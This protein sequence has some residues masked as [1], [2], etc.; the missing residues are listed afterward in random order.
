M[1]RSIFAGFQLAKKYKLS[2]IVF[3]VIIVLL[4]V[5]QV[6]LTNHPIIL[7]E[8]FVKG[9]GWFEIAMIACYGAFIIG[10]M[11]NPLNVPRWRRITS[12]RNR[13]SAA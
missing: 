9:G 3:L 11:Q 6:K 1:N 2:V 5:V 13:G 10:K 12:S 8:R 4:A 7:L